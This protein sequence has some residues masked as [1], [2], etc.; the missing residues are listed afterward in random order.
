MD[1]RIR[2]KLTNFYNFAKTDSDKELINI[3]SIGICIHGSDVWSYR[4]LSRARDSTVQL[5]PGLTPLQGIPRHL[6]RS[7]GMRVAGIPIARL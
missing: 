6:P 4:S 7:H 1:M 3:E 2:A 5:M